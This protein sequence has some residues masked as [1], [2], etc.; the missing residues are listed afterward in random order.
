MVRLLTARSPVRAGAGLT[1]R[2]ALGRLHHRHVDVPQ[3]LTELA[4]A[5]NIH[6]APSGHRHRRAIG[7]GEL[8]LKGGDRRIAC[9]GFELDESDVILKVAFVVLG[10][11]DD[12]LDLELLDA[13]VRVE[14]VALVQ[15]DCDVA[16]DTHIAQ[17]VRGG[18]DPSP[19]KQ[20]TKLREPFGGL[21]RWVGTG[22]GRRRRL[23]IGVG[24]RECWWAFG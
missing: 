7:V 1:C 11:S 2:L 14:R 20:S 22:L 9:V 5:A 12:A 16:V 19:G 18:E 8:L 21:R 13:L 6:R 23:S 24:G 17:T 4:P 15:P 3:R 10:V